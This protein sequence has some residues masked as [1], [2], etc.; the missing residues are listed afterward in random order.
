MLKPLQCTQLKL[1]LQNKI[2]P[3]QQSPGLL[4]LG[5]YMNDRIM[6]KTN[7]V[8]CKQC[9]RDFYK[10]PSDIR[11]SPNHFCSVKCSN[12]YRGAQLITYTC[13][14]CSKKFGLPASKKASEF[15]SL[16]CSVAHR[17]KN[18]APIKCL[19]CA[20]LLQRPAR[21]YGKPSFCDNKCKNNFT[22]QQ[23]VERW[24][25]GDLTGTKGKNR[26]LTQFVRRYIT[27]R[28]IV[29]VLCG[30]SDI[31]NGK[32]LKLQVDHINGRCAESH[33]ENL[34]LLCPNCH[35]QTETYGSKNKNSD[36]FFYN[37]KA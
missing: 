17:K 2:F 37:R 6:C 1:V 21:N 35:T 29:C 26:D 34:R 7:N 32:K 5:F 31:W 24:L 9:H 25:A 20:T 15:C 27:E 16:S 30:Q 22:Y 23:S 10:R 8:I 11:R 4:I 12:I 33:P 36:R 13:N 3:L 18:K 14:E 28:D 19:C